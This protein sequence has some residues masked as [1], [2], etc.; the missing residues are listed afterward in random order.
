MTLARRWGK[1]EDEKITRCQ[2]SA[3]GRFLACCAQRYIPCTFRE[4]LTSGGEFQQGFQ[5]FAKPWRLAGLPRNRLDFL[6]QDFSL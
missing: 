6:A 3:D 5:A 1:F 2:A 4:N